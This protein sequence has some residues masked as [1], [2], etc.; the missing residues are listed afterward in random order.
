MVDGGPRNDAGAAGPQPPAQGAEE[1]ER[2]NR[3]AQVRIRWPKTAACPASCLPTLTH[4]FASPFS[5][6]PMTGKHLR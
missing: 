4:A 6:C 5:A 2:Q 1:V 3:Q